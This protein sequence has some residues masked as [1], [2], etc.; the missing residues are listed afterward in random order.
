MRHLL[1]SHFPT[2]NA[3]DTI[4]GIFWE[5]G[6]WS[7][8]FFRQ[9]T[10]SGRRGASCEASILQSII[11]GLK[12]QLSKIDNTSLNTTHSARN[13]GFIFDEHCSLIRSH[14]F[15]SPAILIFVSSAV[16]V[17]TLILKQPISLLPLLSI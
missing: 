1:D 11:V 12:Q 15:L 8:A 7:Y 10:P 16:S 9:G 4:L 14:H 5:G 6:H 17:L 2:V 13:L 3:R